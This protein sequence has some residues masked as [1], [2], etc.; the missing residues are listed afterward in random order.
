MKFQ[1]LKESKIMKNNNFSCLKHSDV[2]FILLINA[3][4]PIIVGILTSMSRINFMLSLVEYEKF[5]NWGLI[6]VNIVC[7][8]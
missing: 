1:L 4:M 5:Y 3:K 2:V 6:W 8:V 7:F